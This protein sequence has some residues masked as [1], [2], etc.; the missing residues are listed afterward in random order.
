MLSPLLL[1]QSISNKYSLLLSAPATGSERGEGC[2]VCVLRWAAPPPPQPPLC[3][4]GVRGLWVGAPWSVEEAGVQAQRPRLTHEASKT[5]DLMWTE[6]SIL[7]L[8]PAT[9]S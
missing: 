2:T 6:R 1:T 9:H 4:G 7:L 8:K 5:R 3:P